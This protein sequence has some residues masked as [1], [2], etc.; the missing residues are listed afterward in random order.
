MTTD[1]SDR[2]IKFCRRVLEG[3]AI[4][5]EQGG[6]AAASFPAFERLRR[7]LQRIF[8]AGGCRSLVSRTLALCSAKV[9]WLRGLRAKPDGGLEGW[10]EMV[11]K[12]DQP[13]MVEG[14]VMLLA[15]LLGLLMIFLG[16]AI[17]LSLVHEAWPSMGE[18]DFENVML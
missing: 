3:E 10:A 17:T 12:L 2:L 16:P 13:T 15:E 4:I 9:P 14:E 6:A 18:L 11:E 5:V 7:P 1:S 8:G